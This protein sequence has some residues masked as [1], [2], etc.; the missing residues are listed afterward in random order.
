MNKE[1]RVNFRMD[2]KS[3]LAL[4]ALAKERGMTKGA[5]MRY[6]IKKYDGDMT[7]P[8][9]DQVE[10]AAYFED[11]RKIGNNVNSTMREVNC[12]FSPIND[13]ADELH[14]QLEKA[15]PILLSIRDLLQR[16]VR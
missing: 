3:Y 7:L 6:I 12:G 2:E 10:L 15:K 1:K 11:L 4:E 13:K 8:T 14:T 5:M 16:V 9:D